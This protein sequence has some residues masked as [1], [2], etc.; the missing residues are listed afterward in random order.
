MLFMVDLPIGLWA[1]IVPRRMS[2]ATIIEAF[3]IEEQ[4]GL[5]LVLGT[6]GTVMDELAFHGAEEAFHE[7]VIIPRADSV[8]AGLD[9]MS[10]QQRLIGSVGILGSSVPPLS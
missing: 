10:P 3:D 5:R 2:S 1:E 7:C 8:H 9:A 6:I 4:I